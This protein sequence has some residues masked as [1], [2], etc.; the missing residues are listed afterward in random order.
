VFEAV[1]RSYQ[2]TVLDIVRY[3]LMLGFGPPQLCFACAAVV[4]EH[5]EVGGTVSEAE[6]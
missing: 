4:A 2:Q 5:E 6:N 3:N 1:E